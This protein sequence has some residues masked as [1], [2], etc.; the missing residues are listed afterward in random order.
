[1][2][3]KED[4]ERLK[5]QCSELIDDLHTT[6]PTEQEVILDTLIKT[7]CILHDVILTLIKQINND[8]INEG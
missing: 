8:N 1:M 4:L 7:N 2:I 3:H 6:L 5:N